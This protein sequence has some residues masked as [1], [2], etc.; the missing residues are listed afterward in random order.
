MKKS[1]LC[2]FFAVA[3]LAMVHAQDASGS[4]GASASQGQ[5]Q[6]MAKWKAAFDQLDLTDAQK[7]QIKQIRSS[8]TDKQ[9]RRQ[10]IMAV[11]TPEQKQ[12]LFQMIKDN[13]GAAQSGTSGT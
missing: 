11:L 13:R 3:C 7:N 4:T 12:R 5:D 6:R 2:L 10:Q 8:V 1:L 9:Q